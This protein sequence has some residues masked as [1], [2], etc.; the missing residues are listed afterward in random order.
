MKRTLLA[1]ATAVML[2][3]ASTAAFAM[4][5]WVSQG[6]RATQALNLLEARGYGG[7]TDFH[8]VGHDFAANV[9]RNGGTVHLLVNPG[10]DRVQV[11]A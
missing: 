8:A 1:S 4:P 5:L 3:V 10:T 6:R 2:G 9:M 11:A 7:F